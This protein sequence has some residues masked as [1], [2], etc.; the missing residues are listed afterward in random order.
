MVPCNR[1]ASIRSHICELF[2]SIGELFDSGMLSVDT[3]VDMDPALLARHKNV[4]INRNRVI[5]PIGLDVF[6]RS[7]AEMAN[8]HFVVFIQFT[9]GRVFSLHKMAKISSSARE[10]TC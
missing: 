10:Q 6:I 8:L 7:N 9:P 3:S 2:S 4:I 1:F 5:E